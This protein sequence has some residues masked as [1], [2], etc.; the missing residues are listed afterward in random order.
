MFNDDG[1]EC[2]GNY[3]K[4][5]FKALNYLYNSNC[6]FSNND[7]ARELF[8]ILINTNFIARGYNIDQL[9]HKLVSENSILSITKKAG[10]KD[11]FINLFYAC[12]INDADEMGKK[13][14]NR[15]FNYNYILNPNVEEHPDRPVTQVSVS[16]C[17]QYQSKEQ[18]V[19]FFDKH[20]QDFQKMLKTATTKDEKISAIIVFISILELYH[21]FS[22]ANNR[23]F[24]QILLNQLLIE[25]NLSQTIFY[26]PNGFSN[27]TLG[28]LPWEIRFGSKDI[29]NVSI[30]ELTLRLKPAI[31]MVKEG[32]SFFTKITRTH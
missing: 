5:C 13:C 7:N 2:I 30:Q 21:Y 15:I 31:A 27:Y 25:N 23:L 9:Q 4:S 6:Q 11:D 28:I 32:Q 19:N 26:I 16:I 20:L 14:N 22:N 29:S 18:I 24:C 8:D 17:T 12:L 10:V 3:I 1:Y